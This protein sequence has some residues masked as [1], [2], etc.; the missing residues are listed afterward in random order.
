MAPKAGKRVAVV[1]TAYIEADGIP[2]PEP[3]PADRS[4]KSFAWMTVHEYRADRSV[5]Y[6]FTDWNT[7]TPAEDR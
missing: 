2:L 5:P 7:L 1:R 6:A 4:Q 3:D